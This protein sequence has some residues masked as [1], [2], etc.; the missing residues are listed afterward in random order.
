M[1]EFG[2]GKPVLDN[3]I[4]DKSHPERV[5]ETPL[6]LPPQDISLISAI[7]SERLVVEVS[8]GRIEVERDER[9]K[10][11]EALQSKFGLAKM[12]LQQ[13]GVHKIGLS[14]SDVAFLQKLLLDKIQKNEGEK[15]IKKIKMTR[16]RLLQNYTTAVEPRRFE[17]GIDRARDTKRTIRGIIRRLSGKHK[18]FE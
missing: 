1:S 13:P 12:N 14:Y 18:D 9:A 3:E 5:R 16:D 10:Q 4:L 6:E 2:E 8:A 11:L 7:L 15:E 17:T